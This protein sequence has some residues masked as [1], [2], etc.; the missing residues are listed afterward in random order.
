VLTGYFRS[1]RPSSNSPVTLIYRTFA[2]GTFGAALVI[3][4]ALLSAQATV[5]S[6]ES[7]ELRPASP[8]QGET[9]SLRIALPA[10]DSPPAVSFENKMYKL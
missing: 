3:G 2:I 9:L 4:A 10:G 8:K 6:A 5:N 1:V 7:V